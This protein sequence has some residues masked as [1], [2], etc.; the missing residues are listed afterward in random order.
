MEDTRQ[1]T[2]IVIPPPPP[3]RSFRV[4][5]PQREGP[6]PG[7][8]D[9]GLRLLAY[10]IRGCIEAHI[11]LYT[12]KGP[13]FMPKLING[14]C[15]GGGG[16]GGPQLGGMLGRVVARGPCEIPTVAHVSPLPQAK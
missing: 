16:P 5:P 1:P 3:P 11:V 8:L 7:K 13:R 15:G 12:F 6:L 4:S 14:A 9:R 2:L 10:P